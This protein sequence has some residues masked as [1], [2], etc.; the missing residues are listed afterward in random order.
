MI[1]KLDSD[2]VHKRQQELVD[3]I[4]E[5]GFD[6][7]LTVGK[8]FVESIRDIG[9]RSTGTAANEL[10]DNSAQAGAENVHICFGYSDGSRKPSSVA[11]IDD[12]IGMVPGMTR[13]ALLWGGTDRHN[14]RDLFGRFGYGLPSASVS[15]GRRVEV[16]SKPGK[17]GFHR[18]VLD[19]DDIASGKNLSKGRVSIPK[20]EKAKLPEFVVDYIA[21][22]FPGGSEAANTVVVWSSLDRLTFRTT[23]R[24]ENHLLET[25]GVTYRNHLRKI[26]VAVNGKP[27]EPVDPLFTTEGARFYDLD[28]DRAQPEEPLSFDVRDRDTKKVIGKI[29]ARFSVMPPSF[30]SIDKKK[31]ARGGNAN[32]RFAIIKDHNGLIVLRAGRQID[33]VTNGLPTVFVNYDRYVGLEI[34][35]PPALD[36]YFGVTTHKQQITLSE[37]ILQLLDENGVWKTLEQLRKRSREMRA[38]LT[39]AYDSPPNEDDKRPSEIAME[40]AVEFDPPEPESERKA[41]KEE[42]GREAAIDDLVSKGVSRQDAEQVVET[43]EKDR[44]FRVE[45][46]SNPEGPF[47]RAELRGG[48]VVLLVNSKHRFYTDVYAAASGPDGARFRQSLEV[49]LFVMAKAE[50][51]ASGERELFYKSERQL[52][53]SRL[54]VALAKLGDVIDLSPEEAEPIDASGAEGAPV[55]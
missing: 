9:Y 7:G 52:W 54:T 2:A 28:E 11:V 14:N 18:A 12:G 15:Q 39:A 51:E 31:E 50:V 27:A 24:L 33:V 42:E 21:Q 8:A 19:L 4:S 26:G 22:Q 43:V 6:V 10:I 49:V 32:K 17:G 53:S 1:A 38:D 16:Y 25:F 47:Y 55:V 41:K 36:E 20:P 44:P 3:D 30:A 23:D 34:D 40:E 35:F 37:R 48:Q 45:V 29:R 13:A 46:E 5:A